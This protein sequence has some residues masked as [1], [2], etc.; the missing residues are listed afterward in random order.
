MASR[1]T[2]ILSAVAAADRIRLATDARKSFLNYFSCDNPV[3]MGALE[4]VKVDAVGTKQEVVSDSGV[5]PRARNWD[6][7]NGRPIVATMS[8][9]LQVTAK[10]VST[11]VDLVVKLPQAAEGVL[12]IGGQDAPSI[13]KHSLILSLYSIPLSGALAGVRNGSMVVARY[14]PLD[15]HY[16]SPSC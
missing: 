5:L 7:A 4:H 8:E 13:H 2:E 15:L 11:F 10:E 6:A 9:G 1:Q 16:L 12:V 14:V 3:I